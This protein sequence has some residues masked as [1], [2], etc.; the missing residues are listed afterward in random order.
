MPKKH[1]E[2]S[3]AQYGYSN[4]QIQLIMALKITRSLKL[5]HSVLLLT[6]QWSEQVTLKACF[7][8]PTALLC[9][10]LPLKTVALLRENLPLRIYSPTTCKLSSKE[11]YPY[12]VQTR[13]GKL[14]LSMFLCWDAGL[15][16]A[17]LLWRI[18]SPI[19]CKPAF[20]RLCSNGEPKFLISSSNA[21]KKQIYSKDFLKAKEDIK[22]NVLTLLQ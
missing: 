4:T 17:T 19:T 12:P 7:W 22:C 18:C 16:C 11:M 13:F 14:Q 21:F 20:E 1:W 8:G 10:N 2:E 3:S 15:W 5:L 9:T 6:C